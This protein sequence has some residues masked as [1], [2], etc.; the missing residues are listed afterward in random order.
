[1]A[2][3]KTTLIING[4]ER[5]FLCD[6]EADSLAEALRRLGLTG[7]KIGCGKGQCGACSV[8]LDGKVVRSC[9]R[10]MKSVPDYASVTTIEGL[11]TADNLHPLQLAWMVYGGVQCG[12]CSPGF[13]VSAKGLLDENPNPTREDVRAWFQKHRNACRCTGY[14]P[15]VDAV[16]AAAKVLRGEMSKEDLAFKVPGSGTIYNSRYPR[17][18]ALAKV[19]GA[20]DYGD[21][22]AHK[23]DGAAHLAVVQAGVSHASIKSIDF[24]EAE[25][26]PGVIKVI[27]S[28]DVKGINRI[29][30]PIADPQA[31]P[32]AKGFERPILNDAKIFRY[33]D[34]VAVV[35]ADTRE[36]AR[37]A[38]AKVKVEYE[39]LPEYEALSAMADGAMEIHP[40]VPN[41]LLSQPLFK[42]ELA[43]GVI[44]KSA[45]VAGGS[46][47]SSSE[48]HLVIEPDTA[49]AYLD[50]DGVL[51]I[52]CKSLYLQVII[53]TIAH[54]IGMPMNKIRVIENPTG[55]SFGS[56]MSPSMGALVAVCTLALEGRPVTLTMS[57]EEHQHFSGK[58]LASYANARMACDKDGKLTALEFEMAFD[59]GGYTELAPVFAEKGLRFMGVPYAIPNITGLAHVVSSNRSFGTAYRGCGAPQTTTTSEQLMDMLAEKTGLDPFEIRYRNVYRPGDTSNT[60][61]TFRVH[62]M[63]GLM[64]MMRPRY[65]KAVAEAK[66]AST[67]EKRR[68]VGIVCG[69]YNAAPQYADR[70]EVAL[71]LNPDGSVNHY[72]TWEDQGQG[73]DIGTLVHTHEALRPLGLRPDQ[74]H[75]RMN[76]TAYGVV[77][78]PAAGSRSHYMAGNATLDAAKQLMDAMRKPDGTF[79]THAEMVAE[80][81]PTKYKGVH[82]TAG[83]TTKLDPNTFQGDPS[84]EYTYAVYLAEVEVEAATG[85]VK[86]LGM[87][88]TADVGVVGN[89]LA[90]EGQAYGGMMHSLGF[91]LTEDYSDYKKHSNLVP[92][93]F[94]FIES[95]PD[96]DNFTVEFQETPRPTGPHGSSG[97]AELFQTSG[98]T[99]ILNA[100][101]NACGAR[102]YTLPA[103]PEKVKAAMDAK[104]KGQPLVNGPYY[105]GGDFHE[106]IA[107]KLANPVAVEQK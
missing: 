2:T 20:C 8:I 84:G 83:Y 98:H 32:A 4:A 21:D 7:T 40:G 31:H 69:H 92:S 85:K 66:K 53:G 100:I 28:K 81:I 60:G 67:P 24:S 105:M 45:H 16:M 1:M 78:G 30:L 102:I 77:T 99:A 58:R 22:I 106:R 89:Y 11:G 44:E 88:C 74:I 96:G 79:R 61:N 94:T 41:I 50:E 75:L 27:T 18:A 10:K 80:G 36:R 14:K 70:A 25:A 103:T 64:D 37:A 49:Q 73:A 51:V 12:F 3:R 56:T 72:N 93:G 97:A 54:G 5:S 52:Q 13:I 48:P 101:Y 9:A 47:Y 19:L 55:A 91:A 34:V 68:G 29:T 90:V 6:P 63:Q 15:L 39:A 35:A 104:A 82:T 33:G 65:E 87:H 17:P 76:D 71:E 46:F 86:V 57:Y 59:K 26:M 62:P 107:Y 43:D 38:A 23:L 95:M 42:G